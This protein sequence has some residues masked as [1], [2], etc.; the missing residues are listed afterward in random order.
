M[1]MS[2]LQRIRF[3]PPIVWVMLLFTSTRTHGA[4]LRLGE[5]FFRTRE[6]RSVDCIPRCNSSN[7]WGLSGCLSPPRGRWLAEWIQSHSLDSM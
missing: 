3:L 2:Y 7:L 4:I 1:G 5:Q 6:D